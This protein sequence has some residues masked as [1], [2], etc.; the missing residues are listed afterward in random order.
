MILLGQADSSKMQTSAGLGLAG[1][2]KIDGV[3]VVVEPAVG[4]VVEIGVLA[5]GGIVAFQVVASVLDLA[6]VEDTVD[7]ARVEGCFLIA[8]VVEPAVVG[9]DSSGNLVDS[10]FAPVDSSSNP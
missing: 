2:D 1:E 8:A 10:S 9:N 6:N 3:V 4:F 5:F 7:I